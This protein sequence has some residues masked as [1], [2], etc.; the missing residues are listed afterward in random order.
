MNQIM[1]TYPINS[2]GNI[3][4]GSLPKRALAFV[5]QG[6]KGT[7]LIMESREKRDGGN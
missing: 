6:K 4:Q 1:G 3:V 5:K 2:D 7:E